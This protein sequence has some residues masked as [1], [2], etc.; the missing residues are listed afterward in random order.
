MLFRSCSIFHVLSCVIKL[1][2]RTFGFC[3]VCLYTHANLIV[4]ILKCLNV[5]YVI[6]VFLFVTCRSKCVMMLTSAWSC[7]R[8]CGSVGSFHFLSRKGWIFWFKV[9]GLTFIKNRGNSVIIFEMWMHMLTPDFG[10]WMGLLFF[11]M[12]FTALIIWLIQSELCTTLIRPR[13]VLIYNVLK[14]LK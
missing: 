12:L 9:S 1:K 6:S 10:G 13:T 5:V 14:T 11:N 3:F 2:F 8:R 4:Y 7:L